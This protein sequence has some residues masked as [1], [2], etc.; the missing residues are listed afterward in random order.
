M[1]PITFRNSRIVY[2]GPH[3]CSNCGIDIV[4]AGTEF[5]GTA[6][7]NPSGP[8]YPNTEWHPHVCDPA[9]VKKN[10]GA[11]AQNRV[12]IDYPNAHAFKVAELGYVILGEEMHPS[13]AKALCL[14]V[15][16]N[17]TFC[18]TESAAWGSAL[19]RIQ[20]GWPSWHIDMTQ[21]GPHSRFSDD[22]QR[23][24]ERPLV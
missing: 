21:Y 23:L 12:Q 16:A 4:K 13:S 7:T 1:A 19:E 8:I 24:P 18:D 5:G 15:S 22:L 6:F 3:S 20:K 14:V 9:S 2:Y 10:L 17:Q 11:S